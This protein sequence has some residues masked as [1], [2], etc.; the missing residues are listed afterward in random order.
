[1]YQVIFFDKDDTLCPAKNKADSE[2]AQLFSQLLDKY[3]V[4]ITT[5]AMFE[6]IEY[7]MLSE[8]SEK[9]NLENLFL[10]PT[11]AAKMFQ[12]QWWKWCEK[13]AMKLSSGEVDNITNTLNRAIIDLELQPKKV[14]GEIVENRWGTQITYSALWQK[15]P[16]KEKKDWDLDKKKR[17]KIVDYIKD[18]LK[19][20]SIW[21]LGTTSI[22]VIKKWMDKSYGVNKMIEL[23]GFKKEEILYVWDAL[24]PGGNDYVVVKTWIDTKKVDS[25]EDTKKIIKELLTSM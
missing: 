12:Y 18:E 3:K 21:I 17:S 19:D 25:P 8:L 14:W 2:M 22:D 4:V 11:N 15:A 23:Y 5:G 16:L 24:F 9:V 13:Y 20:F 6:Y 10:F 1:M 7:Q